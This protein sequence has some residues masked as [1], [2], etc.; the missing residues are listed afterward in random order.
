MLQ[1]HV[2]L[3]IAAAAVLAQGARRAAQCPRTLPPR[4]CTT[5]SV[6]RMSEV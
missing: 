3:S 5:G 6:P 2:H 1:T 4:V